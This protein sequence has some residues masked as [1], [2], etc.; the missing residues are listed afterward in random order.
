MFSDNSKGCAVDAYNTLAAVLARYYGRRE[1]LSS[2]HDSAPAHLIAVCKP[3]GP[4]LAVKDRERRIE[5]EQKR[6]R[7]RRV[8]PPTTSSWIRHC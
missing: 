3:K 8:H 6:E 7:E 4:L 5:K 1:H 2:R